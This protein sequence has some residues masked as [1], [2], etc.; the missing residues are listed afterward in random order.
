MTT[1]RMAE[2]VVL[3]AILL[4]LI[5]ALATTAYLAHAPAD[6][7]RSHFLHLPPCAMRLYL[8]IPCPLCFGTTTYVL[9]WRGYWGVAL[10]LDPLVFAIFWLSVVSVPVLVWETVSRHPLRHR[11][12]PVPRRVWLALGGTLAGLVLLNWFYLIA[13]LRGVSPDE[14]LRQF[15]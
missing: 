1:D 9:L 2:R 13:T 12:G 4:Y 5:L 14:L 8:G 7:P 11:I 10:R 15:P 6:F 3:G